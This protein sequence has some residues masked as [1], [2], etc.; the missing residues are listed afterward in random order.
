M[1]NDNTVHF[2]SARYIFFFF[3]IITVKEENKSVPVPIESQS[4]E[5]QLNLR[6]TI[7]RARQGNR[8]MKWVYLPFS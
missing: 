3:L 8:E 4:M 1:R 6:H 7:A 5:L 2:F